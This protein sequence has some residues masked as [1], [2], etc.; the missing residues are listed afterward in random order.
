MTWIEHRIECN[1]RDG[2]E[3]AGPGTKG[4]EVLAG[5]R[6]SRRED[7]TWG[8]SRHAAAEET[9]TPAG[10]GFCRVVIF[11]GFLAG[12]CWLV[13]A[14]SPAQ[15]YVSQD[16]HLLDANPRIGSLGIN[17]N[18]RLD[19][20]MPRLDHNLYITGN[21]TRGAS[22]QGLVPYSSFDEFKYASGFGVLDDFRRD[23]VGGGD[24]TGG[25]ITAQPYL[26]TSR[27][28]TRLQGTSVIS[29]QELY[30]ALAGPAGV[31][32]SWAA[33]AAGGG[34]GLSSG[35]GPVR[36]GFSLQVQE[37]YPAPLEWRYLTR[38]PVFS[39]EAESMPGMVEVP[40]EKTSGL[41]PYLSP[42]GQIS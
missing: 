32:G 21:V 1:R 24:L 23:S 19:A 8:S 40:M 20:L 25:L 29:T 11:F 26:E 2:G 42:Q 35:Y 10:M 5:T 4:R 13:P 36:P 38:P 22:F 27:S 14:S 15:Q 3:S 12:G 28:I 17:P 7:H 37:P 41:E 31:S 18:A 34:A 39:R 9:N 6:F 16:G 30:Q 33:N